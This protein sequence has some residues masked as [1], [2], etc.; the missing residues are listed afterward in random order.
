MFFQ[1]AIVA[2]SANLPSSYK[3]KL[4]AQGENVPSTPS[5]HSPERHGRPLLLRSAAAPRSL[6]P[7]GARR[8]EGHVIGRPPPPPTSSGSGDESFHAPHSTTAAR[9]CRFVTLMRVCDVGAAPRLD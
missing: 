9:F 8:C 2:V 1:T 7:G 6:R 3:L 4:Y 5:A